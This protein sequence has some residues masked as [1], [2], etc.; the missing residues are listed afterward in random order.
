VPYLDFEEPLVVQDRNFA[1]CIR[2]GN[3]PSVDGENGLAVVEVL[4]C[5]Q[6]SLQEGRRVKLAEVGAGTRSLN[7]SANHQNESLVESLL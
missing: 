1:D 2:T 4:E 7:G 5:L 3:R 6:I